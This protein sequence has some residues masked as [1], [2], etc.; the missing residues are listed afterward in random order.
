MNTTSSL[1]PSASLRGKNP[2]LIPIFLILI[3]FFWTY[4]AQSMM[5]YYD[6]CHTLN[7]V[8]DQ[9]SL[10]T[11][12]TYAKQRVSVILTATK[13]REEYERHA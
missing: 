1:F 4:A 11:T 6:V 3:L 12:R 2:L 7:T 9:I 13:W 8:C 10:I 5:Q